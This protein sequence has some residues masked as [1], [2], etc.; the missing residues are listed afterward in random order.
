MRDGDVLFDIGANIGVYSLYAALRHPRSKVIAFEPEYA[1]LH[2]LKENVVENGL[3]DRIKVYSLALS[4]R[5]GVS[6]L[7][8]QDLTPGSA[9]HTVSKEILSKTHSGQPVVW[10]EG[11][12][13]IPLDRFCEETALQPNVIKIDVDGAEGLVL[14]GA[15]Q[16][17]RSPWLRSLILESDKLAVRE[18]A[19]RQLLEAGFRRTWWDPQRANEVWCCEERIPAVRSR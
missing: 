16:T 10:K 7:H 15:A 9:L 8:L 6:Q 13:A 18:S 2:L 4:H 12:Y 17:L 14:E 1:N 3:K 11:I 19:S 5:S